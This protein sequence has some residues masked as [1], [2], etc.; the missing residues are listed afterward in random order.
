MLKKISLSGNSIKSTEEKSLYCK[1]NYSLKT[2]ATTKRGSAL[3]FPHHFERNKAD[4]YQ[5]C[6]FFRCCS[7]EQRKKT[8]KTD[9][10]PT[11]F[12]SRIQS[13]L[14]TR[15]TMQVYREHIEFNKVL[16]RKCRCVTVR[17]VFFRAHILFPTFP[18]H[19][20]NVWNMCIK[21]ISGQEYNCWF[22]LCECI[23]RM[24]DTFPMVYRKRI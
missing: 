21:A 22:T 18:S 23:L 24:T 4:F 12:S 11:F 15:C 2:K 7:S 3:P 16:N 1:V 9:K 6:L 8:S 13:T 14:C 17:S 5:F 20:W 10:K 19:E